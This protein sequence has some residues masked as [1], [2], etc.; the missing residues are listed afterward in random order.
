MT[1]INSI[2][3][4]DSPVSDPEIPLDLFYHDPE[5]GTIGLYLKGGMVA[6]IRQNGGSIK[7]PLGP[8]RVS[9][10]LDLFKKN[11][12][13]SGDVVI[14]SWNEMPVAAFMFYNKKKENVMKYKMVNTLILVTKE[15][16]KEKQ[17]EFGL[18]PPT[19]DSIAWGTVLC[20]GPGEKDYTMNTSVGHRVMF[21]TLSGTEV[22]LDGVEYYVLD[23]KHVILMENP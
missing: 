23:D 11:A 9:T 8:M 20:V 10:C 16:E 13:R 6:D 5:A 15:K 3:Y 19:R 1:K 4:Y 12:T 14:Y 22:T 7:S 17:T 21:S 2:K 18:F